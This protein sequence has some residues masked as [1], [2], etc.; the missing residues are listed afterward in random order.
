MSLYRSSN[1]CASFRARV[2]VRSPLPATVSP[3]AA[4]VMG[5]TLSLSAHAQQADADTT[6]TL[7]TATVVADRSGEAARV[8]RVSSGALGDRKAVDTPFSVN[9]VSSDE[10]QQRM[11][12]TA[13]DVFKYD[14]AVQVLG[15]N[16]RT[17]NSYFAV[18]GIRVDMLN[19]TKVDGQNF[20]TWDADIPL[21]PFEQ[22]ELLKGLSG[23]MYGFGSP[24]G[25]INYVTK[26]PTDKPFREV[27]I[28]YQTNNVWSEKVDV[29]G[30]FGNDDRFGYRINAV[31][32]DGNTNEPGVH[33]RRQT[34]SLATDFRITPDLTWNAD[35]MYWKRKSQG[36]I[37]GL[38]FGTDTIPAASSVARNLAQPWSSH[39]TDTLTV[40]TGV[41]YRINSDW[42]T[43]FKYRFA[44]QNRLNADSFLFV[45]D[46]AGNYSDTN[47]RWKTAY[48]YQA[49]D[50]MV[51]GKF[52]TGGLKHEVVAGLGYLSQVRE[53]DN[54]LGSNGIPMGMN[55]LYNPVALP[56][57]PGV[58]KDYIPYRDYRIQQKSVYLSDTVQ[59]TPRVS[60]LAGLRY[61][62]FSQDNYNP[63]AVRT[64]RYSAN[65]ITPTAAVMF[66]TDDFS[67]AYVS[68]VE[69]LEPGGSAG[70]T[71]ANFGE[72]FG[73]LKSRQYEVG[74]KTDRDKWGANV[75][76][77]RVDKGY[78]YT[79]TS[80]VF[81]QNGKQQFTGVDT[82]G[83]WRVARDVRLMG[84]V[85]WLHTKTRDVDDALVNGNRV[86]ATPNYIV[87]GRVEY[88][89]PF[90]PG[91]TLW[92]GAKV[93]GA[94]YVNSANTQQI[95]SYTTADVGAR[96]TT[97]VAGKQVTVRAVLNNVFNRRYWTTTYDGFVLP[98]ATRTFLMNASLQF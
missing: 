20:V 78:E 21:E 56:E 6:A 49:Y 62:M 42:K 10:I 73:P 11:A 81:V 64:S 32:E 33:V 30:R 77:F 65:P 40:G 29:G 93:T 57:Q 90:V 88:D 83:W 47:Y 1:G 45:S 35:I 44:R 74:F 94:M 51:Q 39:E 19:G 18:R 2:S 96:Y 92:T 31:N 82:S 13:N 71:A 38:S 9:A 23:F 48:Y 91:L 98:A 14:P 52:D 84:G 36:T 37:F 8:E 27:T 86:F 26:R 85:L 55:N 61:N 7:P 68:Y 80:N 58:G 95:P 25:I 59:I 12:Q 15:D 79:N 43:S 28:G 50:A 60:V 54:G 69:S 22:V 16:A 34:F 89:T 70:P 87:T 46:D 17:E 97:R 67:T 3:V 66:K 63:D 53:L 76:L 5:L 72:T 24:G 4:A 41:D 75:A